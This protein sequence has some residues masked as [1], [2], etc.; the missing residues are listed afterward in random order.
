M[1]KKIWG[2][3]AGFWLGMALLSAAPITDVCAAE[4]SVTA[5][6]AVLYTNDNTVILADADDSTIV[7]PTVAANCQYK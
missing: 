3:I 5:V 4:Y 7:L 2:G 1:M 6:D